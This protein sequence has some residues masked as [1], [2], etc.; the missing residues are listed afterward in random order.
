MIEVLTVQ[1]EYPF[2]IFIA[3]E[4]SAT[5]H[6]HLVLFTGGLNTSRSNRQSERGFFLVVHVGA[7]SLEILI[8]LQYRLLVLSEFF[9]IDAF[10]R[11]C[12]IFQCL[13]RLGLFAVT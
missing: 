1:A 5:L 11:L 12:Q 10:Y 3:P 8:F 2:K 6:A 7:V 4:L 9:R 13:Q